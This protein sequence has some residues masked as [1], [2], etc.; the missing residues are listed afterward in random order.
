MAEDFLRVLAGDNFESLRAGAEA[1]NGIDADAIAAMREVGVDISG[2]TQ[3]KVDPFMRERVSNLITLCDRENER[4]CPIFPCAFWRL[5]WP[6][7][8]P[9]TA[10]NPAEHCAIV[11]R[12]RDEIRDHLARF[13]R[14]YSTGAN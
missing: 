5:R 13:I 1:E 12:V 9:A 10:K 11:L 3:K 6:I 14:E 7:E 8:N 2:Q 4:T